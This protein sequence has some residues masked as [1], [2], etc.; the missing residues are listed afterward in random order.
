MDINKLEVYG[1]ANLQDHKSNVYKPQDFRPGP[2]R[3]I[4]VVTKPLVK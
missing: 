1:L 4:P 2:S 3:I